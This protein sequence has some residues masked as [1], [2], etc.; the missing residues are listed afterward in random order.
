MGKPKPSPI[1]SNTAELERL[2]DAMAI[3]TLA[4]TKIDP[5]T[6]GAALQRIRQL[7]EE[8]ATLLRWLLKARQ[9]RRK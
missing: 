1:A 9:E 5:V 6:Y 4:V 8:K 3:L 2:S 7:E